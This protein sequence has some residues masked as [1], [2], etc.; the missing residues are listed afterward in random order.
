M[1]A[2]AAV[3]SEKERTEPDSRTNPPPRRRKRTLAALSFRKERE[4]RTDSRSTPPPQAERAQTLAAAVHLCDIQGVHDDR[5]QHRGSPRSQRPLP[6]RQLYSVLLRVL[7]VLGR[8]TAGSQGPL[9][10]R[11]LHCMVLGVLRGHTGHGHSSARRTCATQAL[12]ARRGSS[13]CWPSCP[14]P[15]PHP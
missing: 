14:L 1:T 11:L 3:P 8:C 15:R 12:V 6:Q 2:T 10:Q 9:S 4:S 5:R 7:G 13:V